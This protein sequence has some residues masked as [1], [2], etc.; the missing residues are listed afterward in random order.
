MTSPNHL[1][2]KYKP[3]GGFGYCREK[4]KFESKFVF[5]YFRRSPNAGVARKLKQQPNFKPS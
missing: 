3:A 4:L 1:G 2:V 5:F